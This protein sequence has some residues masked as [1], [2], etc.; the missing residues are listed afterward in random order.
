VA[1]SAVSTFSCAVRVGI[2]LNVW[3]TNPKADALSRAISASGSSARSRL[4]KLTRP[5]VGRSRAAERE[6]EGRLPLP[7]RP[8]DGQELAVLDGQIHAVE[9]AHLGGA[10]AEDLVDVVQL[11]HLAPF[12]HG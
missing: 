7:G 4:S 2:R 10:A 11:V 9:R 1:T 5:E 12:G 8:L 6:Q 3:K